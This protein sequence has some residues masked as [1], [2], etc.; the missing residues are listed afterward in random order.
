MKKNGFIIIA[1]ILFISLSLK[2]V[3]VAQEIQ[4]PV[5]EFA[6]TQLGSPDLGETDASQLEQTDI[7]DKD[8]ICVDGICIDDLVGN[9]FFQWVL[10]VGAIIV[11]GAKFAAKKIKPDFK[12][13]GIPVGAIV[14]W[15]ATKVKVTRKA[16]K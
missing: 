2:T 15:I 9:P 11:G 14:H 13:K 10:V 5:H 12:L 8:E 4:V 16:K 1:W 6:I 7:D 3:V